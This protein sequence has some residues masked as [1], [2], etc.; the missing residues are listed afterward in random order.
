[1]DA[2]RLRFRYPISLLLAKAI[3]ICAALAMPLALGATLARAD[4]DIPADPT[5]T[6]DFETQLQ[7]IC[8]PAKD[9]SITRTIGSPGYYQTANYIQDQIEKLQAAHPGRVVF[10]PVQK[11]P[12][13]SPITQSATLK[14]PDG[15]IVP[16]YPF[17]PAVVRLNTTPQG[18]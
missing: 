15:Q 13:I 18:G 8:Q 5:L 11:F 3:V 1:M 16:I 2:S 12:M 4:D 7:A 17:L 14:L 10:G 9:G 6:Q